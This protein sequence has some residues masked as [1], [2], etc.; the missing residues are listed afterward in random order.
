MSIVRGVVGV[1]TQFLA[2]CTF[3]RNRR[4]VRRPRAG[5]ST[6]SRDAGAVTSAERRVSRQITPTDSAGEPER[7]HRARRR[8]TRDGWN[9]ETESHLTPPCWRVGPEHATMIPA[10]PAPARPTATIFRTARLT[11]A[12]LSS[13]PSRHDRVRLIERRERRPAEPFDE[14]LAV[15][16]VLRGRSSPRT[17]A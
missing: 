1:G 15:R 12:P 11:T 14:H 9:A 17:R 6:R 8:L 4:S 2:Q 13:V 3:Q 10:A 16:S 5:R 7:A